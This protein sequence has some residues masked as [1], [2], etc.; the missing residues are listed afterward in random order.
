MA[1]EDYIPN[2]ST[3]NYHKKL[4]TEMAEEI[5]GFDNTLDDVVWNYP[6]NVLSDL[7]LAAQKGCR[8]SATKPSFFSFL[9]NKFQDNDRKNAEMANDLRSCFIEVE[10]LHFFAFEPEYRV[11][12]AC[13]NRCQQEKKERKIA[14]L[15]VGV[16]FI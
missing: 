12:Y 5:G 7:T 11:L 9:L 3:T 13:R 15:G 6:T 1:D 10:N 8:N 4:A 14:L 2:I 16:D